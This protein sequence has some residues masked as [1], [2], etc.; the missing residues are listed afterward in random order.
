M[1]EWVAW[2]MHSS[3]WV[4]PFLKNLFSLS[5][6]A[7]RHILDRYP[8]YWAF[9]LWSR[10]ILD[11]LKKIF[12]LT[13]CSIDSWQILDPSRFLGFL[14]IA[15]W[16]LLDLLRP[17]CMHCFSHVLY[18]S[19]ILSSIASCFVAFMHLYEFLVPPWSS[20]IIY[21]FLEWSFITSYTLCQSWQKGRENVVSF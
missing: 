10:Q 7:P 3:L 17:Y 20:L 5:S 11:P 1:L 6:T 16:Q 21:M 12:E 14:S 18:L 19:I 2:F 8:F 13:V 4:F 15:A 9:F